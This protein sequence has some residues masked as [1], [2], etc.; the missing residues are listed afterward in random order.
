MAAV[1]SALPPLLVRCCWFSCRCWDSECAPSRG[2]AIVEAVALCTFALCNLGVE[3]SG[4]IARGQLARVRGVGT[5]SSPAS[6][7]SASTNPLSSSVRNKPPPELARLRPR[8]PRVLVGSPRGVAIARPRSCAEVDANRETALRS[9]DD[10]VC[11][12]RLAV[13]FGGVSKEWTVILIGAAD[14]QAR[15]LA[16]CGSPSPVASTTSFNITIDTGPGVLGASGISLGGGLSA[17]LAATFSALCARRDAAAGDG[18][19]T[20]PPAGGRAASMLASPTL[21]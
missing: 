9:R 17:T 4:D 14:A 13:G 2:D 11:A 5:S 21:P 1:C 7:I 16:T 18:A 6:S 15:V 8:A 10:A 12:L 19:L 3:R 20:A